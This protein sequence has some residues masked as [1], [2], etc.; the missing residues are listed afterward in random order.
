[1]TS[2]AS[3]WR[4]SGLAAISVLLLLPVHPRSA[5]AARPVGIVTHSSPAPSA[6]QIAAIMARTVE[7]SSRSTHFVRVGKPLTI[8]DGR[9]TGTLTAAVG[10][11]HPTGDGSGQLT[12]FWHNAHFLGW[13]AKYESRFIIKLRSSGPGSFAVTYARYRAKDAMCCPSRRPLT[14]RSG[15]SGTRLISDG[16]PPK[17]PGTP[18]KVKL[19]RQAG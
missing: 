12:F 3:I 10:V 9:G 18:V 4:A 19:L 11:R 13:D 1:M 6:R 17:G 14:V 15:W 16:V 5:A 2:T 8:A 7:V